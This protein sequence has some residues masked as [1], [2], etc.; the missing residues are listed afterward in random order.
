MEIRQTSES[1]KRTFG[2]KCEERGT[3]VRSDRKSDAMP[4]MR[5]LVKSSVESGAQ[6]VSTPE[7]G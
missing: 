3:I 2:V 4:A 1:A 7:C 6:D 5:E